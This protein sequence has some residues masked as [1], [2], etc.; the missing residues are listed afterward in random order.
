MNDLTQQLHTSAWSATR[1]LFEQ[2]VQEQ[3][4]LTLVVAAME[5][6]MHEIR[7]DLDD[8]EMLVN[9]SGARPNLLEQV[10]TLHHEVGQIEACL[11]KIGQHRTAQTQARWQLWTALVTGLVALVLGILPYLLSPASPKRG[12]ADVS[13]PPSAPRSP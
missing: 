10:Q 4:R 2:L 1:T 8:L 9:K 5:A 12:T 11:T 7:G 13:A 3:Q 6:H